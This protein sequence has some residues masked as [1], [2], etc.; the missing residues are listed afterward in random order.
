MNV[1]TLLILVKRNIVLRYKHSLLGFLWGLIKPIVYLL[2]FIVVFS[3]QFPTSKDYIIYFLSAI[4]FWFYFSNA[5]SQG[6]QSIISSAGIIK[7]IDIDPTLF[8]IAELLSES[9]NLLLGLIAFFIIAPMLGYHFSWYLLLL[10]IY[11]LLFSIF[12][13][14]LMFLLS[15]MQTFFRDTGLLWNTIQPAIFYITPIAYTLDSIPSKFKFVIYLNPVVYF[16]QLFRY[17]LYY[18]KFPETR[19]LLMAT[20]LSTITFAIGYF[21]FRRF[22]TNFISVI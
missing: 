17:S 15:T 3:S 11:L 13:C 1:N 18:N 7:S 9:F 2:I 19:V 20:G 6:M 22:K 14:G 10:P 21:C 12:T 5:V 4:L 16:I 8:I